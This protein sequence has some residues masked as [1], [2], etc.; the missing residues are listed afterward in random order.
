[1]GPG[2]F[3]PGNA[4]GVDCDNC[5]CRASM[6]PG[7]F[8]PGN[9]W[10]AMQQQKQAAG[11]NGAGV[12]RPRK[13]LT[14]CPIRSNTSSL[15]WGRGLSTPEI[16]IAP[17][18]GVQAVAGF[19]G[20][21]VF[22]PRKSGAVVRAAARRS[23]FN[24]AGV[25]RPRKSKQPDGPPAKT[26][27]LQWGRGLS[28]PEMP[29][30]GANRKA[31]SPLQWGRGLSTPEMKKWKL[32]FQTQNCFNGAGVFRPRKCAGSHPSGAEAPRFNGAGVFR[33]RKSGR[34]AQLRLESLASMG[35]GSFDP[36]NQRLPK[37]QRRRIVSFNGAGVFRPRKSAWGSA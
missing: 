37:H 26:K 28:T 21:G 9:D 12:F 23:R 15:Q 4:P 10:I 19:N 32:I 7:S 13:C 17:F 16:C 33:P 2:S 20:A 22:R 14:P 11:F 3:D 34:T 6:G 35:P 5:G 36:G 27:R 29:S 8:D 30:S 18:R 1:M 24:G 25:F 31:Q